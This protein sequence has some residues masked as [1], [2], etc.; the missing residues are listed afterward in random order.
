M[1][2]IFLF[3][4]LLSFFGAEQV[5]AQVRI[6]NLTD[7]KVV[8]SDTKGLTEVVI[9]PKSSGVAIFLS[10]DGIV[11][12]N[13]AR[14]EGFNKVVIG[15]A[16]RLAKNGKLALK[17][18]SLD[19]G[20][21]QAE[22]TK[23]QS[24]PKQATEEKKF[25]SARADA[26]TFRS[27]TP[28]SLGALLESGMVLSNKSS[29]RLTVLDGIFRG[30]ALASGQV[31]RIN[32]TVPTGKLT[33]S[34]YFDPEEDSISS[35]RNHRWAVINKIIVE[36]Q[37]SLIIQDTDLSQVS[38]GEQIKKAVRNNFNIDFLIVAGNNAGEVVPA[39]KMA[40]LD[41]NIGWNYIPVEYLTKDG[42]PVRSILLLMVNNSKKPIVINRR[43]DADLDS[44]NP[45]EIVFSNSE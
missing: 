7:D 28:S 39:K 41:L 29:Y 36:G 27:S 45:G 14:Y 34:I 20:S 43:S 44:V 37:D 17:D 16:T 30:A 22:E 40:Q 13:L 25:G 5:W 11:R 38:N 18:L 31:S 2:K 19:D 23:T 24:Q 10:S 6:F 15:E 8:V 35:G 26:G 3:F 12:F 42:L 1:K 32:K 21:A 4:L 33:F 9:N